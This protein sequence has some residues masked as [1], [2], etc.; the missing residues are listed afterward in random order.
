MEQSGCEAACRHCGARITRLNNPRRDWE[1]RDG[2][3]VCI[4]AVLYP[5]PRPAVPHT[6]MPDGLTGSPIQGTYE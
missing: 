5:T 2:I 4:K 6:P 3:T 1:D